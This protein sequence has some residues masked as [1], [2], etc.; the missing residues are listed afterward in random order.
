MIKCILLYYKLAKSLKKRYK[1]ELNLIHNMPKHMLYFIQQLYTIHIVTK[2]SD[3]H[4][5]K[6]HSIS[7]VIP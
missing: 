2:Q 7:N 5:K 6:L 4:N 3:T 1:S